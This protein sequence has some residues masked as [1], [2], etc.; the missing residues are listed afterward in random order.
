[1]VGAS[2]T[3]DEAAKMSYRMKPGYKIGSRKLLAIFAFL[4][5]TVIALT[6][7]FSWS[8]G[9]TFIYGA[10][11]QMLLITIVLPVV[12]A[13][14]MFRFSRLLEHLREMDNDE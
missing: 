6:I 5:A 8:Q 12:L 11:L 13:L 2:S 4:F 10:P 1:M 14:L 9:M 7:Y 3:D